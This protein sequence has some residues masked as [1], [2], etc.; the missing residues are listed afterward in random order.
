MN[1]R[2]LQFIEYKTNGKQAD[3]ALLVGWIPQYVSKLIKGENFGIRPVI[4]LLKTFPELNAR[5]LLTGEGEM[6]SFNPATS[7]IKDRL[8]RLLELEKY[9]KVMTPAEL[10]QITEGE[11]LD[12]PQETFDKWE[13]LLE[14][15]DKE[16]EERKLEAMN[17][18]KE[19]CKMKIAKK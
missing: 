3:F 13:K 4:T 18:Q 6:L 14:E 12:F 15:R 9:M 10:H 16:W 1:E 19:L 11:N 2:L 17:K 7:V 8:Q 5:W